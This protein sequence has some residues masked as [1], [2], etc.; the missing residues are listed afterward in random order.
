VNLERSLNTLKKIFLAPK[1]PPTIESKFANRDAYQLGSLSHFI[2]SRATGY[3][4]LPQF[5][6]TAPDPGVRTVEV[7]K[8][9]ENPWKKEEKVKGDKKRM[10]KDGSEK[11]FYDSDGSTKLNGNRSET[12]ESSSDSESSESDSS[13]SSD[14][15]EPEPVKPIPASKKKPVTTK[16]PQK[17]KVI[18]V[19][20]KVESESSDSESS[21]D[22]EIDTSKPPTKLTKSKPEALPVK[23]NLDLL[24][25]LED[26]PPSMPTPILTPSLGGFLT[27]ATDLQATTSP[28]PSLGQPMFVTTT[29]TELLN[30][31]VTGGIQVDYRF[32]RHPHIYAP[33]MVS[34]ELT[35]SNLSSEEVG[36]VKLGSRS[37]PPGMSLH[38]FPAFLNL[39]PGQTRSVTLGVDY[40]DTTQPARL[41]LVI[42]G[43]AH[44][45]S[46]SC[47]T[48][49]M[50]RPLIMSQVS[51]TEEQ[52][53]LRGMNEAS[54]NISLPSTSCDVKSVT[55][56]VYQSANVLQV[57]GSLA[58]QLLFA[59]QTVSGA[60][61]VLLV[62]DI[63][64]STVTVNTEKIVLGSML[65]KEVKM[66]LE[67]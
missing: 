38:E 36:E 2:N 57:P 39:Q 12:E 11:N 45:V 22:E 65:V 3:Q 26:I 19:K 58:D 44:S 56:R 1:P 54:S 31:L 41:D 10:K 33:G 20:P 40:N 18:P 17:P 27:P 49:E 24:L 15:S 43:R 30:K 50:V 16:P 37:L 23:S 62:V 6:T 66:A 48:G 46:L 53:K 21:S 7:P 42:G 13:E 5:P 52:A 9:E 14:D 35:F 34:I 51:F 59:G 47:S 29:S 67:K 25:D 64:R 8:P 60:S 4:D 61:L 55:E 28:S 32:T 63:S